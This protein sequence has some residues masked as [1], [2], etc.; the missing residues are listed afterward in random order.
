MWEQWGTV[1]AAL[2]GFGG[3]FVGLLIGRRQVTDQA[4]VEHEQWLRGQRQEAYTRLLDDWETA[5]RAMN[6]V[7]DDEERHRRAEER[8]HDW[9][10]EIVPAIREAV[11]QPWR[12]VWRSVERVELLGPPAAVR[13]AF[14]MYEV[15]GNAVSAL[16]D[17]RH[18]WPHVERVNAARFSA[19]MARRDAVPLIA[20]VL[21][22]APSPRS[23]RGRF[24]RTQAV[25]DRL[26]SR[27]E[28]E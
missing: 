5:V 16:L 1:V 25:R 20:Q 3:V 17:F 2:I 26:L 8:G 15:G 13:A 18:P 14:N 10:T 4:K 9:D 22:E 6:E 12:Q 23:R 28:Q 19:G 11:A 24:S 21:R 27:P 7:I